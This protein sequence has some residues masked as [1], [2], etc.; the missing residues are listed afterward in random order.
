MSKVFI[1]GN[2]FDISLGWNTRY[3]DFAS[4]NRFWPFHNCVDGLSGHL[5]K[6]KILQKWLDIEKELDI[7]FWYNFFF[8]R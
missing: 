2:G 1:I 3:S 7:S 8:S 5:E 4:N 6:N